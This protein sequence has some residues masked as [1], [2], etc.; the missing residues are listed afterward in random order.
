MSESQPQIESPQRLPVPV[1]SRWNWPSLRRWWVRRLIGLVVFLSLYVLSIGP[2]WWAWYIGMYVDPE[3][4]Y[5]VI[6]AYEPLREA[7]RIEFIND[8]VTGYIEW[9]IL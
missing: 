7:C 8:I 5:W 3:S 1:V 6:A 9:W 2:M 4:N